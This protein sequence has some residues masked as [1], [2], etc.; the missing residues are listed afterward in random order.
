MKARRATKLQT[1]TAPTNMKPYAAGVSMMMKI[2][3]NEN[4]Q[5]TTVHSMRMKEAIYQVRMNQALSPM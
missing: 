4:I 1:P 2:K 5:M 3:K